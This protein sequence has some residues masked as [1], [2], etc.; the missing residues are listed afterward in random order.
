MMCFR[1]QYFRR[2]IHWHPLRL[3]IGEGG[4][5]FF[6]DEILRNTEIC[7]QD[8]VAKNQDVVRFEVLVLDSHFVHAVDRLKKTAWPHLHLLP[9]KI[10]PS[11]VREAVNFFEKFR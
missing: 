2:P 4:R 3:C 8:L 5:S 7:D 11:L 9:H 6:I 1:I 10:S